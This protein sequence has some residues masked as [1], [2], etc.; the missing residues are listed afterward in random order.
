MMD[1]VDDADNPTWTALNGDIVGYSRLV[2]DDVERTSATLE[3]YRNLVFRVVEAAAGRVAN[4][5]GD[6]FMAVFPNTEAAVRTAIGLSTT[7]EGRNH[8]RAEPAK[9]QFRMGLDEGPVTVSEGHHHGEALNISARIQAMARPGGVSISGRVYRALDEPALRFHPRGVHRLK[10]I[11]ESVEVY[12]FADLPA[13]AD[14]TSTP[15][16][17]SLEVPTVAVLP[18]HV[19]NLDRSLHGS[20]EIVR[21]DL[22]HQLSA[23]PELNVID[24][25]MRAGSVPEERARYLLETGVH[26]FGETLRAY[27][28]VID[29]TT[30]NV[31]TSHKRTVHQSELFDAS[32]QLSEAVARA[33]EVDLIVGAPA[34]L[35]AE[36][37]DPVTIQQVYQGW[38]HL[39]SGTREGW[40]QAVRLFRTIGA[41]HP[42][43]PYGDGLT[44]F[45]LWSGVDNGWAGDRSEALAEAEALAQRADELGDPTGMAKAVRAA[46]FMSRGEAAKAIATLEEVEI[47]RPT[48]DVTYALEGSVRRYMGEWERAV[49]LLDVAMR[50]TGI[51]KPWYLTVKACSLFIGDRPA[52]AASLAESVLEF[53]PNNLEALLVLAAAQWEQGQER[54]ARGTVEQV[55][56]RFPSLDVAAWLEQNPYVDPSIIERWRTDLAALGLIA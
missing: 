46:I 55:R 48:C 4:F 43:L 47:L 22:L 54:R 16:P 35:Y 20:A 24:A 18:I 23:I 28:I 36:L 51:D 14:R 3:E 49:D 10:N 34:A 39:R 40:E 45:A 30:M 41:T 37:Y 32:E 17:L 27:A 21:G 44:A 38:F 31:V 15:S 7:I 5:A 13:D 9:I 6:N 52:Q 26:Q 25:R 56:D 8:G 33:V 2:A 19:E 42:T 29:V 12:D 50:L 53:Q 1:M 11:P